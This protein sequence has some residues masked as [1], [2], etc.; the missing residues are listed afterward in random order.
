MLKTI[1]NLRVYIDNLVRLRI[2]ELGYIF[3]TTDDRLEVK[4]EYHSDIKSGGYV[5][6]DKSRQEEFLK[7]TQFGQSFIAAC[8][9]DTD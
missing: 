4:T 3:S 8:I 2:V 1:S 9:V 7:V 6:I 5:D